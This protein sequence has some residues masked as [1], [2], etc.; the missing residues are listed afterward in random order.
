MVHK[1]NGVKP[2]LG[3]DPTAIGIMKSFQTYNAKMFA[4]L[5]DLLAAVPEADGTT[6]LDNTLVVWCGQ[7]GGGD[8]SPRAAA[9]RAR[10]R[11]GRPGQAGALR[12]VSAR[13]ERHGLAGVLDRAG[14]QRSVR[15]AGEH[16][17]RAHDHVRQRRRVQGALAGLNG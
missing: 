8:H 9:V 10:G 5:L 1:T 6:L 17:G 2:P 14:A 15:G 4:N 11:D 3:D 7:I 12:A 13:E 16:D